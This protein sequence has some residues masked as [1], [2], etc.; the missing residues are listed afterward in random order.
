ML[1][2]ERTP[3][4]ERMMAIIQMMYSRNGVSRKQLAEEFNIAERSIYRDIKDLRSAYYPIE[5]DEVNKLYKIDKSFGLRALHFT[6]DEAIALLQSVSALSQE[7]FPFSQAL[8]IATEKLFVCLSKTKRNIIRHN[9]SITTVVIPEPYALSRETYDA[10]NQ[11]TLEKCQVKIIYNAATS[12]QE[13]LERTINPYGLIF[14][15]RAWYLVAYCNTRKE[16]RVFRADRISTISVSPQKFT[17][18]KNFCL[19]TFFADSWSIEQGAVTQVRLRFVSEIADNVKKAKYHSS[20]K[21]TDLEDGSVVFE[22]KVRGT[23]E[24]TR[25]IMGFGPA[26]EVLEPAEL[27][28]QVRELIAKAYSMYHDIKV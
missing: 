15:D 8:E 1:K 11:A 18:P 17:M 26:V 4:L 13:I 28:E 24:I 12:S 3:R 27:R 16:V 20:Q 9:L 25:W 19:H 7:G 10:L 5:T 2:D 14:K 6:D 21:L 23:W 22:V